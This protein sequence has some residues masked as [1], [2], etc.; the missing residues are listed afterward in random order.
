MHDLRTID[1][2]KITDG[3]KFEY[4]CRDLWRNNPDFEFIELNGRKGQKQFGVDVFGRN[5]K[6]GEWLGIQ[7][8]VKATNQT[9][10]TADIETEINKAKLFN[11]SLSVFKLCTTLDRDAKIQT[12]VRDIQ[13]E[14][15]K[16]KGFK[17]EILYWDDIEE[18]LKEE[19]NFNIYYKYYQNFFADN[20]TFGHSIG[21]LFNLELGCDNKLDTHYEVMLGKIPDYKN[22]KHENVNYYRGTYFIVNFHQNKM[23]TFTLPCF[24]SDIIEAFPNNYDRFRIAKWINNIKNIDDFICSDETDFI[25][26]ITTADQ[27]QYYD[28]MEE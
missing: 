11:P 18:Q 15:S 13:T 21:K 23:E 27:E 2:P 4:L 6:S 3:E 22:S 24:E 26:F 14:L 1:I 8:K 20:T 12:M 7:C 28:E 10:T 25:H 17:F 16:S 9:L 5:V 19:I